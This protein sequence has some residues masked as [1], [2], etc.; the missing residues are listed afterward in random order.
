MYLEIISLG[1]RRIKY[2]TLTCKETALKFIAISLKA[3]N[4]NKDENYRQKYQHNL[5]LF[6]KHCSFSGEIR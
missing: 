5:Q 3:A 2:P 1:Y 4:P 6:L